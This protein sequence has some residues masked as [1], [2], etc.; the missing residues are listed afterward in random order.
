MSRYIDDKCKD[1]DDYYSR[2]GCTNPDC[3]IYK[4]YQ[5]GREE[6]VADDELERRKDDRLGF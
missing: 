1:C 5:Q 3:G 4:D 6:M 2:Y